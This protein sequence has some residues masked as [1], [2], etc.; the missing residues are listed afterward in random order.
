MIL[1]KTVYQPHSKK[2]G[3]GFYYLQVRLR[4]EGWTNPTKTLH[5]KETVPS[6]KI[7]GLVK[8]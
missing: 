8:Y 3:S 4:E 7:L 5:Q 6:V 2:S 1:R